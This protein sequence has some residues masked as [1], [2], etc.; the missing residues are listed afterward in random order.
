MGASKMGQNGAPGRDRLTSNWD[1]C[2]RFSCVFLALAIPLEKEAQVFVSMCYVIRDR[3]SVSGNLS[4]RF[5]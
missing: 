1:G 2:P 5:V 4:F 3:P